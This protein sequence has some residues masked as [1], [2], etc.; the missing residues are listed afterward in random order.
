MCEQ[1]TSQGRVALGSAGW[2]GG[3]IQASRRS[4]AEQPGLLAPSVPVTQTQVAQTQ[5]RGEASQS[6]ISTYVWIIPISFRRLTSWFAFARPWGVSEPWQ[7]GILR[8]KEGNE[9]RRDWIWIRTV[10]VEDETS[11]FWRLIFLTVLSVAAEMT[12]QESV[13]LLCHL[14]EIYVTA[15]AGHGASLITS[16]EQYF[17]VSIDWVNILTEYRNNQWYWLEEEENPEGITWCL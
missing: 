16:R 14:E 1:N 12:A 15:G 9:G 8:D 7:Y 4:V 17:S 10:E 2:D 6:N 13:M 11:L 5:Q 3:G